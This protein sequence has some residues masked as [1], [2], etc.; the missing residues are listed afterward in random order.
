YVFD[1]SGVASFVD[2]HL[3]GAKLSAAI[4]N[5][6]AE[7]TRLGTTQ[8]AM[9]W[10]GIPLMIVASVATF[11]TMRLSQKRQTEVSMANPQSAM[12]AK[13]MM[14]IAPVGAL[15][16]GWFLPL[17]ILLYWLANNVWT[18]AQS[19]FLSNKVDREQEREREREIA[20]KKAAPR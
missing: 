19:H 9:M 1:R 6:V 10:V 14:Y 4:S 16:A 11:A 15:V 7:L 18:L 3:F 8:A 13:S 2:A 17:A 12:M 20:A 5:P